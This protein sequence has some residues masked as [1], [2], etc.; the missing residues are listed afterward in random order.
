MNTK[1]RTEFIYIIPDKGPDKVPEKQESGD[2]L[3]D[4]RMFP[5]MW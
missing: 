2:K 1:V 5:G 3:N 4:E